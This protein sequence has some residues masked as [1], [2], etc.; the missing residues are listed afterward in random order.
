MS[1]Y[2]LPE[3]QR[4][5]WNTI[6]K[7]K[8]FS[9]D[10]QWFKQV[11]A[12]F[13]QKNASRNL[14]QRE[15]LQLNKETIEYMMRM[16]GL[17]APRTPPAPVDNM[18]GLTSV[19]NVLELTSVDNVR[20]LTSVDNVQGACGG[21]ATSSLTAPAQIEDKKMSIEE[22]NDRINYRNLQDQIDEL[23]AEIKLLKK[24]H[25]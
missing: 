9:K 4:I 15:L 20:G 25:E 11:I 17:T 13:Y 19:D 3:N 14:D 10:E 16:Q 8:G 23:R 2:I 24:N 5:L 21:L 18:R 6:N 7:V 22:M 12:I 1:A